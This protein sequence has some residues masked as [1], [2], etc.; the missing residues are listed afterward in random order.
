M[1]CFTGNILLYLPTPR[2]R[3]MSVGDKLSEAPNYLLLEH[4]SLLGSPYCLTWGHQSSS[5]TAPC[6]SSLLT[7]GMLSSSIFSSPLLA[8]RLRSHRYVCG[9]PL[10]WTAFLR[11]RIQKRPWPLK[12]LRFP[13]CVLQKRGLTLHSWASIQGARLAVPLTR[14]TS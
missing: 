14:N 7:L 11:L 9:F 13:E 2:T 5:Q 8:P 10:H 3:S 6:S 12:P 1:S 4:W